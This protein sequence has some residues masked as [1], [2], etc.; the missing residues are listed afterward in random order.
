MNNSYEIK[1][2]DEHLPNFY[3]K[4]IHQKNYTEDRLTKYYRDQSIAHRINFADSTTMDY[5]INPL[6][7]DFFSSLFY[8]RDSIGEDIG[9]IRI[10][11]N[12][13][14]WKA[15]FS[16]IGEEKIKTFYGNVNTNKYLIECTKISDEP[17]KRSDML[18]NNLIGDGIP[19]IFWFTDDERKLPVK[20][21]FMMKP[22]AVTWKLKSYCK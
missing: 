10:D 5:E 22:F 7:R 19:L 1:Y 8:L 14:I 20:A 11:A 3:K 4:K 18:T 16:K 9:E 21:K 6:S 15:D 12:G 13:N 2:S 17:Q